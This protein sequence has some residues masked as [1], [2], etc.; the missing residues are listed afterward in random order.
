MNHRTTIKR[1]KECE[2]TYLTVVELYDSSTA[3]ITAICMVLRVYQSSQTGLFGNWGTPKTSQLTFQPSVQAMQP[4]E[5]GAND[6]ADRRR[7]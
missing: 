2:K 3:Q 4:C 1:W 7:N 5:K 6:A